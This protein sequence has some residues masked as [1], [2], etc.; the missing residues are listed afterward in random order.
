MDI[1]DVCVYA[2]VLQ[3]RFFFCSE[4]CWR[5]FMCTFEIREKWVRSAWLR[6][7]NADRNMPILLKGSPRNAAAQYFA[8]LKVMGIMDDNGELLEP[9]PR[10]NEKS[11]G[12][13]LS[14]RPAAIRHSKMGPR[15]HRRNNEA[16]RKRF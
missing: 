11:M 8:H 4:D 14:R 12:G 6:E 16:E 15:L 2:S 7:Y 13:K 10:H 3:V 9:P 1:D 5:Y